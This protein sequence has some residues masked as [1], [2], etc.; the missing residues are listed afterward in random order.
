MSPKKELM[1]IQQNDNFVGVKGNKQPAIPL[2]KGV[3]KGY[4]IKFSNSMMF[5]SNTR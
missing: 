2:K 5:E 1:L 4:K 3:R